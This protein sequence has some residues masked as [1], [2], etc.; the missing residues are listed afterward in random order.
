VITVDKVRQAL[1]DDG[2]ERIERGKRSIGRVAHRSTPVFGTLTLTF[3]SSPRTDFFG[4]MRYR[5]APISTIEI[6]GT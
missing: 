6:A 5:P 1:P 3:E 2:K 4:I